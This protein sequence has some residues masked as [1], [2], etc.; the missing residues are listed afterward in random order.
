MRVEDSFELS[1]QTRTITENLVTQHQPIVEGNVI[2]IQGDRARME[3]AVDS[4]DGEIQI[5][6]K[7]HSNHNGQQEPVYLLQWD[8]K[9]QGKDTVCNMSICCSPR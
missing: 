2:R 6:S 5:L 8:V 7:S 3:I 9:L 4:T 1:Q